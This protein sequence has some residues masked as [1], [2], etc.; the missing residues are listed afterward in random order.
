MNSSGKRYPHPHRF[1]VVDVTD[2]RQVAQWAAHV[3]QTV[4]VPDLLIC[5]AAVMNTPAPL[6]EIGA[7]EFD[8]LIDTNIKGVANTI[9]HFVPAMVA[10]GSG[11][12]VTLSS[13]WGTSASPNVAPYCASKFAIEGLT[14]ALSQ[15]LPKGMAAI[16]VSPGVIAT[17]MLTQAFGADASKHQGTEEWVKKAVPFF[18]KLTVKDIGKSLRIAA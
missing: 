9:R 4:G 16:A 15:E 8:S 14:K 13:G 17:D 12:V 7:K 3:L 1:S 18:L 5:N 11:I 2:D 10:A 6:W